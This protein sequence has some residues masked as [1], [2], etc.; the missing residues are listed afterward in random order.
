MKGCNCDLGVS[1][2]GTRLSSSILTFSP[3]T[4]VHG[5]SEIF[6]DILVII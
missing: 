5:D 6:F 3:D 1:R 2:L 4:S